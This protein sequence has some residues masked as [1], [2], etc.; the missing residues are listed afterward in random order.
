[1]IPVEIEITAKSGNH[2]DKG[3]FHTEIMDNKFLTPT[4]A[5]AAVMNAIQYY[6]PDRD[7]VTARVESS[8]RVKGEKD[9]ISFV[10]YMYANDGAGS[11]MGGVRGLRALVPLM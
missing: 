10:D 11:V 9:P 1:M 5:G 6:L 3:A 7:D 8:V 4:L 2:K